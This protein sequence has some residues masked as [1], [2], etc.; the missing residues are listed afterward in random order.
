MTPRRLSIRRRWVPRLISLAVLAGVCAAVVPIPIA[1]PVV[2][3]K[4]RSEPF[5]CQDHACGCLTAAQC[6]NHCCC[7]TDS[8]KVAW[9]RRNGIRPPEFVIAAAERESAQSASAPTSREAGACCQKTSTRDASCS[10][11]G[12]SP[13]KSKWAIAK[14]RPVE[15]HEKASAASRTAPSRGQSEKVAQPKAGSTDHAA[16]T[17]LL[18]ALIQKCQG[19]SSFWHSLPWSVVAPRFELPQRFTPIE[20]TCVVEC[21]RIPH[22]SLQPPAPPPRNV[23]FSA[24]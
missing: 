16:R 19:H 24:V 5:P 15:R 13:F 3:R 7:M 12:C 9:S 17:F 23:H 2:G 11:K 1:V 14:V 6:W 10:S 22:V 4:D 21:V 18:T 20:A 8:S